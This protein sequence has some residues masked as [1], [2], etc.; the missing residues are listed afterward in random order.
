MSKIGNIFFGYHS[1]PFGKNK[2]N[3]GSF[4][5]CILIQGYK[6]SMHYGKNSISSHNSKYS[7]V[8]QQSK[9][10]NSQEQKANKQNKN[11]KNASKQIHQTATKRITCKTCRSAAKRSKKCELHSFRLSTRGFSVGSTLMPPARVPRFVVNLLRLAS[12]AAASFRLA[13]TFECD[14]NS[15]PAPLV[16]VL[17]TLEYKLL[18]LLLL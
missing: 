1:N 18:L 4:Y 10:P 2:P 16:C 13:S 7:Q 6:W 14:E 17:N 9:T 3:I 5:I 11:K 15:P 8:R 12:G